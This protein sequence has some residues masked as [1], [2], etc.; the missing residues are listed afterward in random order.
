MALAQYRRD[1]RTAPHAVYNDL[2]EHRGMGVLRIDVSRVDVPR[3]DGEHL[4]VFLAQRA[5]QRRRVADGD[6]LVGPVIDEVDGWLAIHR[7]L[8]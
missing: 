5:H 2:V 8:L 1:Q 7:H 4:D 3:H 6:F